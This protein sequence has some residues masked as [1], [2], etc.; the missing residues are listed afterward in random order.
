M[1]GSDAVYAAQELTGM[2][3]GVRKLQNAEKTIILEYFNVNRSL[4]DTFIR[5]LLLVKQYRVEVWI[6]KQ[7]N[8]GWVPEFKV[9]LLSS[10]TSL[11][12]SYVFCNWFSILCM[13][14]L[15]LLAEIVKIVI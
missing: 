1:Y 14:Y 2:T 5:D 6:N 9:K 13:T 7:R 8:V 15:T 3:T 11:E 10:K 4:F 12:I